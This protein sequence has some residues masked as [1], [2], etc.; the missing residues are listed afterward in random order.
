M[1]VVAVIRESWK[2]LKESQLSLVAGSLAY[3]TILSVIPLLAVSL[4]IF[5]AFGGMERLYATI[6]PFI[7][8]N[9]A[10]GSGEQAIAAIR[11]FIANTHAGTLGATGLAA[12]I[13]TT[14]SMLSSVEA[15]INRVW[16]VESRRTLFHRIAAYWLFITLGPVGLAFVLGL[17]TSK[18]IPVANL[19]PNGILVFFITV[20]VFFCVYK[21]T[22]ARQ[23]YWKP[24]FV[25]ALSTSVVWNLARLAY[26]LYAS[27]AVSYHAIYGSLSAIP[28]LLL[29]IYILWLIVL[30]GAALTA[31]LQKRVE[32][33]RR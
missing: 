31:A 27:R 3:T 23:V 16:R 29:W 20:G 32:A 11:G 4:S 12:V 28:L 22:P 7:L 24:A 14:M 25:G 8:D 1:P 17:A 15:A 19:L 2:R 13:F 10:H 5:Q 30:A 21:W 6:E 18:R 26:Q 33:L 9:L